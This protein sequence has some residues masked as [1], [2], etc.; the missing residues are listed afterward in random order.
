MGEVTHEQA[1]LILRLYDLRREPRL[2]EARA[3]FAGNFYAQS[4]EE[5][6]EIC[7]PGSAANA[8]MRMVIT[9]WEMAAGMA[10]RG[11]VDDEMFFENAGEAFLVYDRIRGLLPAMRAAYQNPH[12]WAQLETLGKRMEAWHEKRAPGH[13]AA[14]RQRMARMRPAAA[15]TASE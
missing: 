1:H 12:L 15:K 8:S 14:M 4:P 6:T 2:R 10:N 5:V 11:L 13:V 7:P 3:W 9:Y